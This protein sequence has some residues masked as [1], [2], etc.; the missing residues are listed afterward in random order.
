MMDIFEAIAK[1]FSYRGEFMDE[2]ISRHHLKKIVQ[3]GIDAP[4]G[5]N[6]QSTSFVVVDKPEVIAEI[7][8]LIGDKPVCKTATAMIACVCDKTPA[9]GK[10]SF[11]IEDCAAATQNMWLALT[12]IGLASVWLDGVIRGDVGV[13]IGKLLK[14]PANLEVRVLL[15]IGYP[16]NKDGKPNPKKSLQERVRFI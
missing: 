13:E 4:S 6:A 12:A 3:A 5:C 14:V 2:P 1:R 16:I 7:S 11:F 8:K 9:Y 10:M 15:P